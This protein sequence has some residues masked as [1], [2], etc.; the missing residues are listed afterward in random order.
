[1]AENLLLIL[2]CSRAKSPDR[3]NNLSFMAE[4][5]HTALVDLPEELRTSIIDGR[6]ATK[7]ALD[8]SS[9]FPIPSLSGGAHFRDAPLNH[10]P[11]A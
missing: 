10:R 4:E 1:M 2:P 6:N 9:R 3:T 5:D 8:P 7:D 11:V